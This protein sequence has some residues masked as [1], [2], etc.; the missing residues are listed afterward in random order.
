MFN[1]LTARTSSSN[2]KIN[3]IGTPYLKKLCKY[4]IMIPFSRLIFFSFPPNTSFSYNYDKKVALYPT[5]KIVVRYNGW[6]YHFMKCLCIN[7]SNFRTPSWLSF[8][9]FDEMIS[10]CYSYASSTFLIWI[11]KLHVVKFKW[12]IFNVFPISF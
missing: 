8:I 1:D 6:C 10:V 3:F 4:G 11:I 9:C 12:L 2:A 7:V 5:G